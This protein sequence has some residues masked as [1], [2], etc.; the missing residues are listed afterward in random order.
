[1]ELYAIIAL[2]FM[3]LLLIVRIIRLER[4]LNVFDEWADW[5]EKE[6]LNR[7]DE[8]VFYLNFDGKEEDDVSEN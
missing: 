6:F 4:R 5:I 7:E 1:M 8:M 3:V 2:S